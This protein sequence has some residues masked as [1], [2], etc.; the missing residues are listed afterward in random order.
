MTY[1]SLLLQFVVGQPLYCINT[2]DYTGNL[3]THTL[4]EEICNIS[5]YFRNVTTILIP[6]SFSSE[7]DL[8]SLKLGVW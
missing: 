1:V 8:L 4:P 3:D 6:K 7:R 2:L 5:S